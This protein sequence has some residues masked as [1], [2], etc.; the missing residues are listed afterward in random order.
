MSASKYMMTSDYFKSV[1]EI[2]LAGNPVA[3]AAK[4]MEH[5]ICGCFTWDSTQIPGCILHTDITTGTSDRTSG[6]T[7]R[8]MS[9]SNYQLFRIP[10]LL[11]NNLWQIRLEQCASLGTTLLP[12]P[13]SYKDQLAVASQGKAITDIKILEGT[14]DLVD[15]SGM[16]VDRTYLRGNIPTD[17][18][19]TEQCFGVDTAYF[20]NQN[21]TS[22]FYTY[23]TNICAY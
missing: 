4:C 5:A 11:D 8:G 12:A 13:I 14:A 17:P 18:V 23:F 19:D 10:R 22:E 1:D 7:Y 2:V 3:C 6:Q 21:C 20:F 15:S 9:L 16:T